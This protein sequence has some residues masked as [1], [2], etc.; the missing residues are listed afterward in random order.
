MSKSYL[1]NDQESRVNPEF[2]GITE[3]Y[4]QL[5]KQRQQVDVQR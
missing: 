4:S 5:R 1:L 3:K 2:K